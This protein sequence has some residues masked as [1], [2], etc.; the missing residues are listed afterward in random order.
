MLYVSSLKVDLHIVIRFTI[1]VDS[2]LELLTQSKLWLINHR[3]NQ[4]FTLHYKHKMSIVSCAI[5]R[6]RIKTFV[7]ET[8]EIVCA[9]A[10]F[11]HN[12]ILSTGFEFTERARNSYFP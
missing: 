5:H 4:Q 6:D 1:N 10:S 9:L 8:N 7:I 3:L 2:D 11:Y 12:F